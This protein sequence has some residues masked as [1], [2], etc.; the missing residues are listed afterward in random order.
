[1]FL[2][3]D[4]LSEPSYLALFDAKRNIIDSQNWPVKLKEFDTLSEKI[5]EF[6]LRNSIHYKQL[7]GIVV[8]V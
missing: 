3:L 2:F 6:L 5:D 4:T 7:S 1:M 8:I